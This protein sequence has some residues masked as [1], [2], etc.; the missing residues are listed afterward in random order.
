MDPEEMAGSSFDSHPMITS[1]FVSSISRLKR[2]VLP[3]LRRL[4]QFNDRTLLVSFC[5][6]RC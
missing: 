5:S 1:G 6:W 3:V 4:L 2:D